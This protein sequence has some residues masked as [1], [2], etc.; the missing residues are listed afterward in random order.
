MHFLNFDV[1]DLFIGVILSFTFTIV[2]YICFFNK[3][4]K[5]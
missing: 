5:A 1:N 4:Q 3:E 2:V